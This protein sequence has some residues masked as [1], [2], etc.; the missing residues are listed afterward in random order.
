MQK[1]LTDIIKHAEENTKVAYANRINFLYLGDHEIAELR[2]LTDAEDLIKAK[3]HTL[4]EMTPKGLKYTKRYCTMDDLGSCSECSKGITVKSFI[5]LWAYVFKVYHTV[6]NPKLEQYQ[7][8][9]KWTP[10]K[11]RDGKTYFIEEINGPMVFRISVGAKQVYQNTLAGFARDYGTLIDRNY[12]VSRTGKSLD[13]VYSINPLKES[14]MPD[15]AKDLVLPDLGEV[16]IG[17]IKSFDQS[18]QV[19]DSKPVNPEEELFGANGAL[20]STEQLF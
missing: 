4:Q 7:D 1:G 13:T 2:F 15:G 14:T 9:K 17:K 3:V 10:E 12:R 11:L 16:V 19:D 8:A 20:L 6:Q 5:Y 18:E